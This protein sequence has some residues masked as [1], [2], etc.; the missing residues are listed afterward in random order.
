MN[1]NVNKKKKLRSDKLPVLGKS[2]VVL[3]R[4]IVQ[5]LSDKRRRK[6]KNERANEISAKHGRATANQVV[7]YA[8]GSIYPNYLSDRI[9]L[10]L[11][12]NAKI[13]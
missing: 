9:I 10:L 3:S 6:K 4:S 2:R 11:L 5:D 12:F 13:H 1:M 7:V 8:P